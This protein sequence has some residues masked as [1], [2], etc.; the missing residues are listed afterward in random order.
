MTYFLQRALP[1]KLLLKSH[2]NTAALTVFICVSFSSHLFQYMTVDFV[3]AFFQ[4]TLNFVNK[5]SRVKSGKNCGIDLL[6]L[7]GSHRVFLAFL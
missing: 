4:V 1:K 2:L 5:K 3:H 7:C 6:K